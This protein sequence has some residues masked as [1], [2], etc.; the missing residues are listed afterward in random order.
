MKYLFMAFALF[1]MTTSQAQATENRILV[2]DIH[3]FINS[4]NSAI[5]S[6]NLHVGRNFINRTTTENAIFK[7]KVSIYNQ[8]VNPWNRV[9][10]NSPATAYGVYYRYP[11]NPYYNPTSMNS[12]RK[13][14]HINQLENKKRMIPGYQ[15]H[16]EI[17]G[18][19]VNPY[20]QSAVI[21]VDM[22]E[23]SMSYTPYYPSL[24]TQIQHASS[25]CK[26]YLSKMGSD[27]LLTRMD[28]NTNSSLP[29]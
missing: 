29:F 24:S 16:M 13:W 25:K 26:M 6:P 19:T 4:A 15:S 3:Q 2:T 12:L 17:T 27:L 5:N 9:W 11:H 22:K 1:A 7:N 28:C 8:T 10:Y 23:Y 18:T 21:D 20:G 14:D